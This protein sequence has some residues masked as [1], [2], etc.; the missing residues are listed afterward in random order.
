MTPSTI[1]DLQAL[2][3]RIRDDHAQ[4]FSIVDEE[5]ERGL[6]AIAVPIVDRQN[7]VVAALNLGTGVIINGG[8]GVTVQSSTCVGNGVDG[9]A[10]FGFGVKALKIVKNAVIGNVMNGI[11]IGSV[12][13]GSFVVEIV[14]SWQGL[15]DLMYQALQARDLYLVAGCAAAGSC[16]LALGILLSDLALAAVDPRVEEP[17]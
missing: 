1:T 8:Q 10:A 17:A 14:M 12:L 2:F 9:I 15:G 11:T 3:D 13:S 16:G 6:R 7:Q 4:G 5:L